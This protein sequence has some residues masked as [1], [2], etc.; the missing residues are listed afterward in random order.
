MKTLIAAAA[1]ALLYGAWFWSVCE[2]DLC[3]GGY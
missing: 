2:C 3:V 1:A